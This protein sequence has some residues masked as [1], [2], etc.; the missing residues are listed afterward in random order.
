MAT[1][2]LST[3]Q[4]VNLAT[5]PASGTPGQIYY[6]TTSNSFKYYN[7]T[8][9]VA[10]SSGGGGASLPDQT[11]NEGKYLVTNGFTASWEIADAT[12]LNGEGAEFYLDWVNVIQKPD[13]TITLGGDLTGSTTL[14][15]LTSQTL[16]ATVVDDS[17][18]HTTS[19]ITNFT[20][21]VQDVVGGMVAGNTEN[22]LTVTYDDNTGK[23]NFDVFDPTITLTGDITG[24]ATMSNL[25]NVSISTTNSDRGSSQNIFK[26]FAVSGQ[27]NI[28]ADNND[29]TL[30][31]AAGTGITLT[32]NV[33]TDTLTVANSGVTSL[34]GTENRVTV[35][36][37]SGSI[38][39]SSPQD[40]HTSATPQFAGIGIGG[41][42]PATGVTISTGKTTLASSVVG[43]ASLNIV[44]GTAPTSPTSGD[45]WIA[46][47]LINY[48]TSSSSTKVVAF[49][50]SNITGNSATSTKLSTARTIQLGGD[51][52]GSAS[53]D[54]SA[55]ITIT[56]TIGADSVTLGT[57]TT[58]DYV[59][60]ITGTS[61][62]ITVSGTGTE[63][64]AA[65]LS[66]PSA[67][68]FPGSVTLNADPTQA[69]QAA[70]K[71]Y[72]DAVSQGLHIHASAQVATTEN[73]SNLSSPPATIDG[74]T[75]TNNMRVLVKNQST[76]SQNG[77]YIFNAGAL[78]R[79]I[80]FD[81]S[82]EIQGGDFIFVTGGTQN[83]N[84]GWVQT[85]TVT[86]IG[87]DPIIFQ[88]FSGAG[89]YTAGT[90]I[91]LNGNQFSNAGVL[92]IN[93]SAG[94]V[95]GIATTAGNL[96]QFASTTSSQ[97]LGI[98]SDETG[99]GSLVFSNSPTLT[100]P[101]IGA[102]T[103][104]SLS[105]TGSIQ[106]NS[107]NGL[108]VLATD[109]GGS[110]QMGKTDNTSSTPYIDF[111]SGATTVDFDVR[112]QA[113]GGNGSNGNGTLTVTGSLITEASSANHV[114]LRIPH[115][116]A[117][118]TLANG[119]IWTTT[120]GLFARI[121]GETQQYSKL[122]SPSFTGIPTAP[123][124]AQGTNT[125]QIATTQFVQQSLTQGSTQIT[126][127]DTISFNGKISR[128]LPTYLGNTVNIDSS[129]KLFMNING[130][131]QLASESPS[132][133]WQ[134]GIATNGYYID[135]F[136]FIVLPEAP[137]VG[138]YMEARLM[139]GIGVQ[140][141]PKTYPFRAIDIYL[142]T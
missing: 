101:N 120:T 38:T 89:T 23:L 142:G 48:R 25:S 84:T 76:N 87:S 105:V 5:D 82:A 53:F 32:T 31:F 97:L 90:G 52:S 83:D 118:T 30:T 137:E 67:V 91:T 40:I 10:I 63:G 1:R 116:T 124:A 51:L 26:N 62:Q 45:I 13:P 119:D 139:S 102:A 88:Q 114:G 129:I 110:I 103:G 64:R 113:S 59:S 58:G 8:S 131:M 35:S 42:A 15:D 7:G 43:A 135:E 85:E 127:L 60:T 49:T 93:G 22:G 136:G 47:D 12:T 78:T 18:N 54:G 121:N 77:I 57:D 68:T 133:V 69:L 86:T 115:G 140:E 14:T 74:V 33:T 126:Q 72:V 27:S 4:F 80:D 61:N 104:S 117:P 34:T 130:I 36:A 73:I 46:S 98:I 24:S 11:G 111:N 65:T 16:T 123:T 20:E 109:A 112:L 92:S 125:T 29:D 39:L 66:F 17:H 141:R 41:T 70:T 94:A 106:S 99:T 50:D 6:N 96:S 44:T 100:T 128:F 19:T 81:S 71:Q 21:D 95:T 107:S 9:W 55:D 79:A 56:A 37:S 108:V 138:S 28:V 122:S 75:L 3:K 132:T 2:Q 134:S